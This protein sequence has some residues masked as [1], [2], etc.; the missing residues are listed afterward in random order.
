MLSADDPHL[1]EHQDGTVPGQAVGLLAPKMCWRAEKFP[2]APVST[3]ARADGSTRPFA[4][5]RVELVPH[6]RADRVLPPPAVE[7]DNDE[8]ARALDDRRLVLALN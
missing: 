6:R 3:M 1:V 5:D 4:E 2:S 8:T 7:R